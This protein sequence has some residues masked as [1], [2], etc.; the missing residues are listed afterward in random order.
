MEAI[1]GG[2]APEQGLGPISTKRGLE[3]LAT[4]GEKASA[5]EAVVQ[6]TRCFFIETK[7]SPDSDVECVKWIFAMNS[8]PELKTSFDIARSNGCLKAIS[9]QLGKDEAPRSRAAKQVER[10]AFRRGGGGATAGKG[11]MTQRK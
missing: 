3:M 7:E 9:L 2:K 4:W 11:K 6:A 8:H 1:E 10:L 5:K